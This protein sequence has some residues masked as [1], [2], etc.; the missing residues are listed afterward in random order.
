MGDLDTIRKE[1]NKSFNNNREPYDT[2]S[3]YKEE[4][5][6]IQ[7]LFQFYLFRSYFSEVVIRDISSNKA[8]M[9]W[10]MKWVYSIYEITAFPFRG[11][12]EDMRENLRK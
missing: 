2:N 7:F 3:E 12:V 9:N 5:W 11:V 8:E 4:V 1:L 10:L 6:I